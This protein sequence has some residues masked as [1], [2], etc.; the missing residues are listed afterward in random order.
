MN[1]VS[2]VQG[3]ISFKEKAK[4]CKT[5]GIKEERGVSS[6]PFVH[7]LLCLAICFSIY[8]RCTL[9]LC[10]TLSL[11]T[12]THTRTNEVGKKLKTEVNS[13]IQSFI[14]T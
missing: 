10:P 12:H 6:A 5:V 9:S 8:C 4:Y 14:S 13:L 11:E 1:A 7:S 2:V 3:F